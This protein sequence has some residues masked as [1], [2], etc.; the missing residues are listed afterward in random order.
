MASHPQSSVTADRLFA[1]APH[2]LI[3]DAAI[4][5]A[6]F[7]LWCV[8]HR[9]AWLHEPPE[10]PRLC[11]EMRQDDRVPDRRSVYRWLGELEVNGWLDWQK[12]PGKATLNRFVVRSERNPVTL[13]S[14]VA[15][16]VTPESQPVTPESQPVTLR[17][18]VP[19]IYPH[20]E[21][22]KNGSQNHKILRDQ[23][24]PPPTMSH[25]PRESSGGGG[26]NETEDLL[27]DYR[28]SSTGIREFRDLPPDVVRAELEIARKNGM[29]PG[30]LVKRW[31]DKRPVAAAALDR[32]PAPVLAPGLPASELKKLRDKHEHR[33]MP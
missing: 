30:A 19:P 6:A 15:E 21:R 10:I 17:S 13:R 3:N 27:Y 11:E 12:T 24:S 2:G 29:G 31:R 5:H 9:L 25:P 7:R 23:E 16:P 4:S 18:Q 26:F 22:I 33:S 1:P 20:S 14:Q 8:L 28:F 32:P